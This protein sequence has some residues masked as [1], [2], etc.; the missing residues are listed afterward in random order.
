MF[1]GGKA[2]EIRM[3]KN[4]KPSRQERR[5][6]RKSRRG[7]ITFLI[8]AFIL[9]IV[10]NV[11]MSFNNRLETMIVRTGTEEESITTDGYLFREQTVIPA[12]AEGY[13]YC[14]ADEEQRVKI[15]ETVAYIYKN[16]IST[17]AMGELKAIEG[18]IAKLEGS[19][20]KKDIYSNDTA[21][22]EQS[23][24]RELS[25]VPALGFEGRL[26]EVNEIKGSVNSLIEDRRIITGEAQPQDNSEE[27]Q[28]LKQKKAELE[29]KYNI[30]RTIVH[31]PTSGAFTA[32]VDGLEEM[33][34]LKLVD[35]ITPGYLK[36]LDKKSVKAT[37]D[38]WVENGQLMGKI[39][40]NFSW[41]VAALISADLAEDM[42]VGDR[43]DIRFPEIDVRT[44]EATVSKITPEENGKVVVVAQSN[45]YV[46]QIYSTSK[47]KVELI[48]HHYEGYKIPS[49]SIRIADGAT[50]VYVI[51]NDKA[52]FLPVD[53]IYNS[54]EWVIAAESSDK[55]ATIKLYDELI[56]SGKKLYNNK[57]VR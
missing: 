31:A 49:R 45:K 6:K 41:S 40:N 34:D 51:R 32:R 52:R 38:T 54:K 5:K 33:L 39:V 12:P 42:D 19:L 21:K 17:S 11:V 27:L 23:I 48:K 35:E 9:C 22:I 8:G 3:D 15:G 1:V 46:D 29:S 10:V 24:A 44:I 53:I 36:E 18:E 14:E 56:V 47:M 4:K 20:L 57:V 55:G 16:E 50:G 28:Q 26:D 7:F 25:R 13:L 30:E 2:M 37:T 43:I